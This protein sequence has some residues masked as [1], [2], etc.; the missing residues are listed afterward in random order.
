[1]LVYAIDF[2]TSNSLLAAADDRTIHAPIPLE[3]EAPDPAILRSILFF[4]SRKQVYYGARAIREFVANDLE[5]RLVRSVKKFLPIRSFIGTFIEERPM[6]LEDLIGIFLKEMR[7]R[8]N[9]HFGEDVDR[10]VLGRPARFSDEDD[11]DQFAQYRLER[12]ARFAGFK[13]IEFVPEPVAAAR[14]FSRHLREE[15]LVLVADYGGG[16]S[17]YTVIRL[18]PRPFKPAD[19]LSI[20]GVSLAGDA[21]DGAI[22]RHKLARHFGADVRYVVPF[23]SNVLSM[24]PHLMEK[25]CAPADISMLRKRDTL[26]FFENVRQWTL[27]PEDREKMDRLFSLIHNQLGFG[28]FEAIEGTKRAL[29]EHD[30]TVF[31]FDYPDVEIEEKLSRKEFES[32]AEEPLRRI[33]DSLDE[34]LKRAGVSASEIDAVCCTGGTA[35]VPA[36]R[37]ELEA[38][39]GA[40]KIQAHR[41][42]HSIVEG[43]A[44]RARE[45]VQS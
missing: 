33:V 12:A 28:I 29:S 15:K 42:F 21:L 44:E 38:R 18:G 3:P 19:V 26:A 10:V 20:G 43:L 9:A 6:N 4:P 13:H 7:T 17:D 11:A 36:I 31:R 2:G 34:T 25:I 35:Q 32:C 39:F 27:G 14:E 23:G 45:L 41:H 16:T 5:G 22:M 37:R 40:P 24:P 30:R 1:M 8:A